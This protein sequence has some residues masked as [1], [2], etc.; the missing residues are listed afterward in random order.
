MRVRSFAACFLSL[1]LA[2]CSGP[3]TAGIR[4]SRIGELSSIE[5]AP[6]A[7]KVSGLQLFGDAASWWDQAEGLYPRGATPQPGAVLVFRASGRLPYG[8][9]SVV[10]RVLSRREIQVSQANW[11][12]HYLGQRDSVV[13]VSDRNDWSA[14][15]VWWAPSQAMGAT[16]YSAYGFVGPS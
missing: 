15:R 7:R 8:H 1:G 14:V 9:V 13:D 5:C 10:S 11:V 4:E 16:T 6:Y 3:R 2:A 12:H